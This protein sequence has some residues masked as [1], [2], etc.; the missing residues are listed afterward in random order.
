MS[1][2]IK[3]IE[4]NEILTVD[5]VQETKPSKVEVAKKYVKPVL[6]GL[7]AVTLLVGA[8]MLGGKVASNKSNVEEFDYEDFEE[9]FTD[10]E[11]T[12]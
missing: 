12:E 1:K 4:E 11:E 6:K 8:F 7:G 10:V 3:K 5:T 9:D 2:E